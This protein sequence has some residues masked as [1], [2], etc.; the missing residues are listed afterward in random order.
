MCLP[1]ESHLRKVRRKLEKKEVLT[2]DDKRNFV[3][4]RTIVVKQ[5]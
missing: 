5:N 2:A 1:S 3:V 4:G